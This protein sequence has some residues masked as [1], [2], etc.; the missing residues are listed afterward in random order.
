MTIFAT[1]LGETE[2]VGDRIKLADRWPAGW[3]AAL[4]QI[5]DLTS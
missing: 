3:L 4:Q 1:P 2:L 5:K